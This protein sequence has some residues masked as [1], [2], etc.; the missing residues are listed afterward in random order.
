[1]ISSPKSPISEVYDKMYSSKTTKQKVAMSSSSSN[2]AIRVRI[3]GEDEE[4]KKLP[5][6]SVP[7]FIRSAVFDVAMK[8]KMLAENT[9]IETMDIPEVI[10]NTAT[11]KTYINGEEAS[12]VKPNGCI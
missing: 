2:N 12:Y 9:S 3:G 10:R 7:S 4:E 6:S 5:S 11:I 8:N 1:M